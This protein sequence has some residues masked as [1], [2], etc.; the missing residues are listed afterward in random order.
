MGGHDKAEYAN[1]TEKEPSKGS[2]KGKRKK[3]GWD[4][5]YLLTI[6][7]QFAQLR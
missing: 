7:Q 2:K 3:A 5:D 6:I 4:D 1:V